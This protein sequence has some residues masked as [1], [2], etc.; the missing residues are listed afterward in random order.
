MGG[1]E[2][3]NITTGHGHRPANSRRGLAMSDRHACD[4]LPAQIVNFGGRD[5]DIAGNQL[6]ADLANGT[7][8]PEQGLAHKDQ[9]IIGDIAAPRNKLLQRFGVKCASAVAAL[10][11]GFVGNKRAGHAKDGLA[12]GLLYYKSSAAGTHLG[13]R[14]ETDNRRAWE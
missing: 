2:M 10:C 8:P 7:M 3:K 13:L 12:P 11:H 4:E 9:Q 14:S 1:I 6:D 5:P